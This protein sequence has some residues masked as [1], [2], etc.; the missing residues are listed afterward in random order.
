VKTN[1]QFTE[2]QRNS[3]TGCWPLAKKPQDSAI[4]FPFSKTHK[5]VFRQKRKNSER[6]ENLGAIAQRFSMKF[7]CEAEASRLRPTFRRH[8]LARKEKSSSLR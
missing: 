8:A 6:N 3:L 5:T 2:N 1:V 4:I 7:P